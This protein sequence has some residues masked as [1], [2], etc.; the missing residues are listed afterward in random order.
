MPGCLG[1]V[2]PRTPAR[3]ARTSSEVSSPKTETG[4][5]SEA[6]LCAL[7][8]DLENKRLNARPT[9]DER[10]VAFVTFRVSSS[11]ES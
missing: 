3:R 1:G 7:L 9:E 4:E 2:L 5:V 10:F 6:D 11:W 8:G